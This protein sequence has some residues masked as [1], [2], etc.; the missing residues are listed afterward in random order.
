MKLTINIDTHMIGPWVFGGQTRE[1]GK[2][3][4]KQTHY[5]R[6]IVLCGLQLLFEQPNQPQL[7]WS[8]G[9]GMQLRGVAALQGTYCGC[10]TLWIQWPLQRRVIA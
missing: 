1:V 7:D 3:L 5:V 6:F 8:A 2:K 4:D 10:T 9:G